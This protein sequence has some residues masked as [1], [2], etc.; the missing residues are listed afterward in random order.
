MPCCLKS[1][2]KNSQYIVCT[3]TKRSLMPSPKRSNLPRYKRRYCQGPCFQERT[4]APS[5]IFVLRHIGI[6]Y[7]QDLYWNITYW[8]D[9]IGDILPGSEGQ[10][11]RNRSFTGAAPHPSMVN[12]GQLANLVNSLLDPSRPEL[13]RRYTYVSCGE[14]SSAPP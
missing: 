13:Q 14:I 3:L 1:R 8:K 2:G 4:A 7:P 11:R 9:G 6:F 10:G 12:T 5:V